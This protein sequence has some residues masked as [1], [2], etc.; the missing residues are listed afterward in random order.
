[1]ARCQVEDPPTEL[2]VV[3]RDSR[4]LD[5]MI[6]WKDTSWTERVTTEKSFRPP[7]VKVTA[8]TRF[9]DRSYELLSDLAHIVVDMERVDKFRD[10]RLIDA[11][12]CLPRAIDD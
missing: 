4:L 5:W 1:M 7:I 6:D 3:R 12:V 9:V 10:D 8:R 11:C 2:P